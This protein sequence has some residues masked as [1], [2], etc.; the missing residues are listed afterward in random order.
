MGKDIRKPKSLTLVKGIFTVL[1]Y[2]HSA[3]VHSSLVLPE[4]ELSSW[5]HAEEK[6][7]YLASDYD[8]LKLKINKTIFC[9]FVKLSAPRMHFSLTSVFI[10]KRNT[11]TDVNKTAVF[12]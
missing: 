2:L 1:V 3:A 4:E 10:S 5:D 9:Y 7:K 11:R 8:S 12:T 6:D